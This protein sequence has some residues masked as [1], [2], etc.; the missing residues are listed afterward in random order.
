MAGVEFEEFYLHTR[1]RLVASLAVLIGN[2]D[3]AAEA[4]DEAFERALLRWSRVSLMESP[5][6]WTYRVA[7]NHARRQARRRSMEGR[8][9]PRRPGHAHIP[10]ELVEV[11]ELLDQLAPKQRAAMT[12][13]VLG[14]LTETEI[15]Q[16][17][18]VSRTTVQSALLDA[19]RHLSALTEHPDRD[20]SVNESSEVER[21]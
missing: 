1:D 6:G 14:D 11:R 13:R 9:L 4:A 5:T 2:V 21:T 17:L 10:V 15:G 3:V 18:G 19:R 16:V 8:L 12:L 7:L 20:P